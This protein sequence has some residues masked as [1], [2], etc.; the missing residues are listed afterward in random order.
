MRLQIIQPTHYRSPSNRSL[1]KTKKRSVVNLILPYLAALAPKEWDVQLVDEQLS[2][3]DFNAPVDV[4]AITAW[5][6]N[7]LRAYDI[8]DRFRKRGVQVLMGGPHTFFHEEEAAEHCDA[9]GKGEGE[10]IWPLMLADAASGR[11]R[12]FYRATGLHSLEN[13]PLPRYELVDP[14]PYGRFRTYS[15]QSSRGCPFKCEFCSERLYLGETYRY[16][17]TK[18]VI[19]EIRFT[20]A[21]NILFA[22]SNF[23]GN[24]PHTM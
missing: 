22:D 8:A 14:R 4:V 24:V 3:V 21:K 10:T 19:E 18:D 2:D 5:T 16:R 13:L 15:V 7:S 17:P 23:A 20:R 6:M 9:V 1:H 12:K 11:L